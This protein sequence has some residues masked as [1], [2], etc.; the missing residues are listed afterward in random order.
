M[1]VSNDTIGNPFLN[2]FAEGLD[3]TQITCEP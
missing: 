3:N 2:N 1:I